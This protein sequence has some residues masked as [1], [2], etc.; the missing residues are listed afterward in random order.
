VD[1]IE[2]GKEGWKKRYYSEKFGVKTE[3]E[4]K[5]LRRAIK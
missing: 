5:E 2:L 3:E 1:K 4:M